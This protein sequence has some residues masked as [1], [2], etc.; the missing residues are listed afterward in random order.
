MLW[1]ATPRSARSHELAH[2]LFGELRQ[3]H[4]RPGYPPSYVAAEPKQLSGDVLAV[5]RGR[6]DKDRSALELPNEGMQYSEG[7]SVGQ[8]CIVDCEAH[9]LFLGNRL[10]VGSQRR[11]DLRRV[12]RLRR[13]MA[14]GQ[15]GYQRGQ[16]RK[17]VWIGTRH[18]RCSP[19]ART[20]KPACG[21]PA[22]ANSTRRS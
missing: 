8:M 12:A 17:R 5:C 2:F 4:R 14:I 1:G 10:T 19:T 21:R 3:S 6:D 18:T 13:L 9:G 15:F 7:H 20:A 22:R 11:G 16:D